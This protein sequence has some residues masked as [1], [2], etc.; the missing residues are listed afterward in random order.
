MLIS[1]DSP[2]LEG[3]FLG[4]P[5]KVKEICVHLCLSVAGFRFIPIPC[6]AWRKNGV[7]ENILSFLLKSHLDVVLCRC[8]RRKGARSLTFQGPERP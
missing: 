6:L 7:R 8:E 2:F 4:F 5:G 1:C 3:M